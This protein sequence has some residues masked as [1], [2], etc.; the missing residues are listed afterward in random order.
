MPDIM[1]D[2]LE[3]VLPLATKQMLKAFMAKKMLTQ[4]QVEDAMRTFPY[5]GTDVRN[6]PTPCANKVFLAHD[7]SL[8]QTGT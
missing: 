7:H 6:K 8:K 3:G 1:H 4:A 5:K 2:V